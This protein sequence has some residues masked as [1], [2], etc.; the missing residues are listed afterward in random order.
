MSSVIPENAAQAQRSKPRAAAAPA[1]S[2]ASAP[3][4][5]PASPSAPAPGAVRTAPASAAS[6]QSTA[7]SGAEQTLPISNIKPNPD[8]PRTS[9]K[10][11]DLRE[12]A[13]S[14]KREGL[15]QPLLVRP[16][17]DGY[18]IVAGERRYQ[19]CKMIGL[20]QVPVRIIAA[21]DA[22]AVELA[23]V[24]NIQRS[25]LNPMEEARGYK[26]IMESGGMTQ[27]ELA[28][29]VSKGRSTIANALRL[30]ELPEVAQQLLY[31]GVI[32]AGH[33][34]AIL[35]IPTEAGR[36][37]LAEKLKSGTLTVRQAESMAKML[38]GEVAVPAERTPAPETFKKVSRELSGVLETKARVRTVRGK[39]KIEIEFK[40]EDDLK[41]I[42]ARIVGE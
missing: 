42:F 37:K 11:D 16:V 6:A 23:M 34:R 24:E 26:R 40:D 17:A 25:D 30:L 12:L 9:F 7:A 10:E 41:R 35:S 5:A 28:A 13:A 22:H 4:K 31:D 1:A 14:I 38:A 36:Q 2:S 21:S 20:A 15:L 8:Q 39:N 18:Q 33:A 32:S 3:A 27:A 19:A 29:A